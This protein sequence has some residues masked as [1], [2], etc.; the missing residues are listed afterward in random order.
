MVKYDNNIVRHLLRDKT[1][2]DDE[3]KE[4]SPLIS[5]SVCLTCAKINHQPS[6]KI[7]A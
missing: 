4:E 3:C 7:N 5:A 2:V 6:T 1:E